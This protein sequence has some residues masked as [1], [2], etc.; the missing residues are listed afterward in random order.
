MQQGHSLAGRPARADRQSFTRM[1]SSN[2]LYLTLPATGNGPARAVADALYR[3]ARE[4]LMDAGARILCERLLVAPDAQADALAARREA[5]SGLAD[6]VLP[7]VLL[8][9]RADGTSVHGVQLHAVL[10]DVT[11]ETVEHDGRPVGRRLTQGDRTWLM[12][13]GLGNAEAG[14]PAEQATAMF[15]EADAIL[16]RFG[17]SFHDVAR[18]WLWLNDINTWYD[19][20]NTVRSS[21]F[22]TRGLIDVENQRTYLPASTG[23]GIEPAGGR[24]CAMDLIALPGDRGSIQRFDAGGAQNSAFDYGSAFSRATVAPMPGGPTAFISGTA[25]IDCQG[26]TEHTG[27]TDAQIDAT[28]R[29]LRAL[30]KQLH[31][32]NDRA[33]FALVYA[34]DESVLRRWRQRWSTTVDW[35]NIAVVGEVCRPD[36][37]FEVELTAQPT[38]VPAWH[39]R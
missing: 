21:F 28:L 34:K 38:A 4:A 22:R 33:L 30:L 3:K 6:D 39:A 5:L 24:A 36:L 17:G 26:R 23:I 15:N 18:T 2:E 7:T 12:L 37:L 10:G 32:P 13:N 16:S 8:A 35:P 1:A 20:L 27:D 25:A 11:I 9:P 29:Q 19:Q 14:G 31:C